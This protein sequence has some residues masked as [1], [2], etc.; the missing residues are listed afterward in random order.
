MKRFLATLVLF[1]IMMVSFSYPAQAQESP[2]IKLG[3]EV[4]FSRYFHLIQDKKV[5]LVTN[6]SGVSSKGIS[7]IDAL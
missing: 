2:V 6:Q 4:L 7:T 1:M 5:G 3:N